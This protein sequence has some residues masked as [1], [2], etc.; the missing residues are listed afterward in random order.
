MA[1]EPALSPLLTC[2]L[3]GARPV[4]LA[5]SH[6]E[7]GDRGTL[8]GAERALLCADC[9]EEWRFDGPTAELLAALRSWCPDCWSLRAPARLCR[10]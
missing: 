3:H 4:K 5:C 10:G 1:S 2:P 8:F 9:V 6:L 7:P